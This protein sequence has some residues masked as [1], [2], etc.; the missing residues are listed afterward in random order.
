MI[1][2]VML[3]EDTLEALANLMDLL[4][5]EGMEV[6]PA[7]NGQDALDKLYLYKPDLIITDLRMPKMDGFTFI[8]KLKNTEEFK[9]IPVLVFSANATPE[10]EKKCLDL[11]ASKFLKKPCPTEVLLEAIHST[12]SAGSRLT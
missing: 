11:G 10:N 8:E 3:V 2:K 7:T 4:R 12:L 1:K 9:L 5:L 6:I